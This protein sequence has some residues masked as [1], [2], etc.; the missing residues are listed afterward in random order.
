MKR[1]FITLVIF[2]TPVILTL[3]QEVEAFKPSGK[4]TVKIFSNYHSTFSDGASHSA[5]EV[6]RGLFGYGYNFNESWS[7]SI[8]FDIANPAAGE[9]EMT[10]FLKEASLKYS[11]NNVSVAFGLVGTKQFKTQE[12]F[13]GYR[14]IS[15]SFQDEYKFG[16]SADLGITVT[17]NFSDVISADFSLLN[18]EGYKKLENDSLLKVGLG[19]TLS[20]AKGLTIRGYSDFMGDNDVQSTFAT[21]VGYTAKQFSVGA[22]YNSQKNHEMEQGNDLEGISLYSTVKLKKINLFGRYDNLTS[23]DGY[24]FTAGLEFRPVKGVKIA[25]NFQGWDPQVDSESFVSSVFLNC[26]LKF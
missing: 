2:I 5:F 22:E 8:M 23:D 9:L 12:D 18:G 4:P 26:E 13:W 1:V 14:Y 6:T 21:F 25:P 16:S 20:P 19:V 15:K 11:H 7:G 24:G 3:A 17:Y 10:A